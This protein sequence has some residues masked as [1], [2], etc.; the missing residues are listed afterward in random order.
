MLKMHP[1]LLN[2]LAS[3]F[4]GQFSFLSFSHHGFHLLFHLLM[5]FLGHPILEIAPFFHFLEP[6]VGLFG[7]KPTGFHFPVQMGLHPFPFEFL[8]LLP[9]RPTQGLHFFLGRFMAKLTRM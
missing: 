3:L 8:A 1:H 2:F 9:V 5:D 4:L 6:P 7:T